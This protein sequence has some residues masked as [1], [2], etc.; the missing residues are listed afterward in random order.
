M[1]YLFQIELQFKRA[2]HF[3]KENINSTLD[4]IDGVFINNTRIVVF[5]MDEHNQVQNFN[6]HL[7]GVMVIILATNVT[8]M[9]NWI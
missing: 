4:T 6:S 9:F 5:F 3:I 1:T 8:L 2:T 7:T